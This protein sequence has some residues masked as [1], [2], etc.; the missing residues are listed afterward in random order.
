MMGLTQIKKFYAGQREDWPL[1]NE[2]V[3]QMQKAR[4]REIRVDGFQIRLQ[5]NAQRMRSSCA[6][7]Q[8]Q[9]IAS[10]PCFLCPEQ[11]PSQQKSLLWGAYEIL[12]NPFPVLPFHLTVVSVEHRPQSLKE[13]LGDFVDLAMILEGHTVFYNGPRSGASAPDHLHFQSVQDCLPVFSDPLFVEENWKVSESFPGI[14][15]YIERGLRKY[16]CF[17]GTPDSLAFCVRKLWEEGFFQMEEY[18]PEEAGNEPDWNWMATSS[19]GILTL[20]IFPRTAHRPSCFYRGKG[21]RLI[22]PGALDMAGLLILPREED[23]LSLTIE[24]I[25]EVFEEV[26]PAAEAWDSPSQGSQYSWKEIL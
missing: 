10:R 16:W 5:H 4:L 22:S 11:R 20:L 12:V 9:D 2:N 26:S 13:V 23:F 14:T 24:E 8:P 7:V 17:R 6:G 1:F 19:E 21:R 18:M 25:R 15:L 3:R